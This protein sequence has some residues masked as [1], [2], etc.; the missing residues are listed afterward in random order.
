MHDGCWHTIVLTF[1]VL[2]NFWTCVVLFL[3]N[4]SL[5]YSSCVL[6]LCSSTVSNENEL[7][8]KR[9]SLEVFSGRWNTR[10]GPS[11]QFL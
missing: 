7:L 8:I 4:S 2:V 10:A 9:I 5:L 11:V 6:G 1:L 3:F